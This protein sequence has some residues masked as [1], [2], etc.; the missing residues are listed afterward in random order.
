MSGHR[1]HRMLEPGFVPTSGGGVKARSHAGRAIG[2]GLL[3]GSVALVSVAPTAASASRVTQSGTA[4]LM[5]VTTAPRLPFGARSIGS[6]S[7]TAA[8]SG[9]VVL[10]LPN[11]AAVQQFIAGATN[12]RSPS[13]H[14]YLPR[15]EF[16]KVFGPS[17]ATIAAVETELR[18]SGLK[19][20]GVSSNG[21]LVDF[22]GTAS[23][24][25]AAFHTGLEKVHLADGSVGQ[26]TT[27]AVSLP[28]AIAS[29]VQA[30]VGLDQLVHEQ[31]RMGA[32]KSST[33]HAAVGAS[34]KATPYGGPVACASALAQQQIGGLTDQQ[35]ASSY[36]LNPL[37]TAGD[38]GAGQTVDVYEL[39]PFAM[40]DLT[41]FD[42]CYF[43]NGNSGVTTV[44]NVDGGPGSGFGGGEAALDVED[45]SAM[46]P[47]ANIHVF[48]GPNMNSQF[49]PV[50]TWNAIAVADDA[51]Q[52]ST[53]WGVCETSL[54]Q[55]APGTQEAENEIFEQ[56]AAQGQTVFSAAGDDGS[57]DCAGHAS[58]PVATDLSLDDPASQPYVVSVGGTT[59]LNPSE[60]PVETVWNNG[61][62][63]GAGG[64]GISE[65]WAMPSWQAGV[66][67]SQTAPTQPCSNDPG[68]TLADNFHL[69]G[70]GTT[71]PSGTSCRETPDVSALADPQSGIT[72]V[73]GGGFTVIGGTS[74]STPLWAGML[75]EMN[76]SSYC[77]SASIG[78]AA[79]LFYQVAQS[80]ASNYAQAF[81]DVTVGNN[82][83]LAVGGATDFAAGT[84][85]DMATGLGTPRVT[86]SNGAPGLAQQLCAAAAGAKSGPGP[87]VT[88]LSPA[89]GTVPGG[90][91]A[92]IT[93]TNFGSSTG[94][95]Y[96]GTFPAHV[97]SWA[98]G[99]ITV[100]IPD[101]TTD[102]APPGTPVGAGGRA[103]ITV[104]TSAHES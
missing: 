56:T 33:H 51:S 86:D 66:A 59:I 52:V 80:G 63:G 42:S 87:I 15:G 68:G 98:A 53:S 89:T 38:L 95:V 21:I 92:T 23:Q 94:A 20:G 50:D 49:G 27:S 58:N 31:S 57:D 43:P 8:E 69:A 1:R 24:V 97:T 79:P 17:S 5:S 32:R 104:V 65:T 18:L 35:V 28:A 12:P 34:G 3:L 72:I 77:T 7:A 75:A 96:F 93:G 76:A 44:T 36:G 82:D 45:V 67:I 4:R 13:Y 102:I 37:Y 103:L 81:S 55:G 71:L 19:V 83:N 30:V 90:G 47:G 73:Y 11:E 39:E 46:A 54:Q 61:T 48:S 29:H 101:Y 91:S 40:S 64:G 99:S 100:T 22:S 62:D 70:I 78:F 9:A 60:P 10:R 84:G 16:G 41:A 2:A 6:V 74:S 88:G 25:E 14:H 26:A 85:Y